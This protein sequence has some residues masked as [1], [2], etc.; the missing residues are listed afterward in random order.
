MVD[1]RKI[2]INE[3][4]EFKRLNWRNRNPKNLKFDF[5]ELTKIR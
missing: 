1:N 5:Y 2:K 3:K 4:S